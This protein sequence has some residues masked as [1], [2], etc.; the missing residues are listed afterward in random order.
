MGAALVAVSVAGAQPREPA[1]TPPIAF[2]SGQLDRDLVVMRVNGSRRRVLTPVGRDDSEPAWSPDGL[3]IAFSFYNGRR[4]RI[5]LFELGTGLV[6]DLGDGFNPDWSPDGRRLVFLDAEGLDDLVTMNANGSNRRK[7]GLGGTGIADET[8]PAW[9]PNGREIAFVGDGLWIVDASSGKERRVRQEGG[10]GAATWSPDGQTLAFDCTT[11]RFHVCLVRTDGTRFRGLTRKGRHPNWS[12]RGD[13]IATTRQDILKPGILVFR[14]NGRIVHALRNGS[15][16]ADWSPDGNRLVA[17]RELVGGPRLYATDS[18]RGS[19]V[20]LTQGSFRDTAASW[21]PDGSSIALRRHVHGRCTITILDA[22]TRKART[23]VPR[24]VDVGCID[25][26]SWSPDG[27]RVYF[28]SRGD[29]WWV[30]R[31][32]GQPRRLTRSREL[33]RSPRVAPDGRSIG[34]VDRAGAWRLLPASGERSLLVTGALDFSWSHD[35]RSIA[36]LLWDGANEEADLYV[37]TGSGDARKLFDGTEDAPSWSPDDR[38]LVLSYTT[39]RPETSVL[40]VTDLAGN[41]TDLVDDATQPDWRP[42]GTK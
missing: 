26:P 18:S 25:Q 35:G 37:R 5:G 13:L 34:F 8:D 28:S 14:T 17:E 33:E 19:M 10:P 41:V 24:T 4:N 29:L 38:R 23:L 2:S 20:R 22:T 39:S 36:Y 7:L 16:S 3:R 30:P 11:R 32:G 15:A 1:T 40:A 12:P 27:R 21:S 6:R 31:G 42:S 9:S